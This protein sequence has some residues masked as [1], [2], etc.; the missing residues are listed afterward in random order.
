MASHAFVAPPSQSS[1]AEAPALVASWASTTATWANV[2]HWP[3]RMWLYR[4]SSNVLTGWRSRYL[5]G[6]DNLIHCDIFRTRDI[7][8]AADK[9]PCREALY[10]ASANTL[11]CETTGK[12]PIVYRQTVTLTIRPRCRAKPPRSVGD[13][14]IVRSHLASPPSPP[15]STGTLAGFCATQA[16]TSEKTKQLS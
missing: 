3:V 13:R 12:E 4:T 8:G 6:Q 16:R 11:L 10:P 14:N 2:G 7:H 9:T 1:G 15:F 5:K